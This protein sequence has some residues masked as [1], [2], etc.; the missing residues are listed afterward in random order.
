METHRRPSVR[1]SIPSNLRAMDRFLHW[2]AQAISI[3]ASVHCMGTEGPAELIYVVVCA[4]G[5]TSTAANHESS[6]C[7]SRT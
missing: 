7:N 1:S 5:T 4:T 2:I 3:L 6:N